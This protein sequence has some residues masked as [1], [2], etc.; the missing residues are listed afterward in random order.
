MKQVNMILEDNDVGLILPHIL[1]FAK[2]IRILDITPAAEP[3]LLLEHPPQKA[4]AKARQKKR[5]H[6]TPESR[7][8]IR[9]AIRE[10]LKVDVV[11]PARIAAW[12][13]EFNVP[14][15]TVHNVLFSMKAKGE[16]EAFKKRNGPNSYRLP[17]K[18]NAA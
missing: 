13:E 12:A 11:T 2:E 10:C 14:N 1:R 17:S 8:P 3:T 16:I 18:S 4:F 9:A 5:Q 15:R 6:K 7:E